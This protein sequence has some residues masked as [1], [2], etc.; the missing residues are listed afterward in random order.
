[1]GLGAVADVAAGLIA[2]GRDPETPAAVIERGT[3]P[4]QR[5]VTAPLGELADAADTCSP[6]A[7][8]VVGDVVSLA[9]SIEP[10]LEQ[11]AGV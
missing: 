5:V 1:M 9:G 4:E 11:L 6:P 3:L 10:R 7:L 2:A 8:I